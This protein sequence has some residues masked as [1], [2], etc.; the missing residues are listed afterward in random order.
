MAP[1]QLPDVRW[2]AN[3]VFIRHGLS[4]VNV[5]SQV[6]DLPIHDNHFEYIVDPSLTSTGAKATK[7]NGKS[8]FKTLSKIP[9]FKD[10]FNLLISSNL[11]RAIETAY[12]IYPG[13][14]PVTILPYL[15]ETG[16]RIVN[17]KTG[18]SKSHA[19]NRPHAMSTQKKNLSS[20]G[21][22]TRYDFMNKSNWDVPSGIAKF[23]QWFGEGGRFLLILGQTLKPNQFKSRSFNIIIVTHGGILNDFLKKHQPNFDGPPDNNEAYYGSVCYDTKGSIVNIG[24]FHNVNYSDLIGVNQ[25]PTTFNYYLCKD[26]RASNA[27]KKALTQIGKIDCA[28]SAFH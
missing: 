8:L 11:T 10:G 13:E 4:T 23:L 9:R 21:I 19:W 22:A 2:T 28:K 5:L 3:I 24:S 17:A 12:Y 27:Y 20:H 15:K 26:K 7:Q 18:T 25:F 16:P 1:L 14:M 6:S